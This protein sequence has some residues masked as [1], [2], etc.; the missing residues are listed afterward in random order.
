MASLYL[1]LCNAYKYQLRKNGK[2]KE[3]SQKAVN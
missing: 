1:K 2:K 3:D